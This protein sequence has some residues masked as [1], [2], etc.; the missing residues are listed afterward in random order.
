MHTFTHVILTLATAASVTGAPSS[1]G[2]H[3]REISKPGISKR[4]DPGPFTTQL[5][6]NDNSN[7][8]WD[9]RSGGEYTVTWD[10]PSGGNF[11]VGKGY[12]GQEMLFNYSGSFEVDPS[13]NAYLGLYGW[14]KEPL[15][16]YYVIENTGIHHPADN[17]NSTCHGYFESDGATYEVWSKWRIN[18]PSIIGNADFQQYWSVRTKRHVGGTINTARHFAAW[19]EAGLPLGEQQ[20]MAMGIEGQYGAGEAE[21]TV[22]V[23]PTTSVAETTTHTTRTERPMQTNPC[24]KKLLD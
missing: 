10:N 4:Q 9:G 15:A 5:W 20:N 2:P 19:V 14:T 11:V 6:G 16:E 18:A 3:A 13:A 24:P 7:F 22:G 21:I 23:A 8:E 1:Y 17:R 12:K